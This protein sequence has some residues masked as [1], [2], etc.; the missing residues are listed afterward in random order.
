MSAS[1]RKPGAAPAKPTRIQVG[2]GLLVSVPVGD[3]GSNVGA[4]GGFSLLHARVRAQ[5]RQG[6]WRPYVDGL[7]G[8]TDVV[9]KT[10]VD[11]SEADCRILA[12]ILLAI[13]KSDCQPAKAG[14]RSL[15]SAV[16][17]RISAWPTVVRVSLPAHGLHRWVA[18]LGSRRSCTPGDRISRN[19]SIST[20]SS[21]AAR[22]PLMARAGS[23]VDR[24]S[25]FPSGPCPRSFTRNI[26]PA[27]SARLTR[28]S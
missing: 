7:F 6:R 19:I 17:E 9:T 3:F 28:A 23:R 15:T 8:L 24:R 13:L 22:W 26:S 18:R 25:C 4:G 2:G 11:A 27:C 16:P 14:K 5:P 12:E 1:N 10:S 21:P 20:T